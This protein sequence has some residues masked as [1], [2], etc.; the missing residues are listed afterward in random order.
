MLAWCLSIV[1]LVL[2]AGIVSIGLSIVGMA[3]HAGIVPV[4]LLY[5]WRSMLA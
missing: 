2:Y 3:L 1:G 5:D 4:Y